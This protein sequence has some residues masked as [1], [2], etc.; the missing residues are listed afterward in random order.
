M[1][2][3]PSETNMWQDH[4]QQIPVTEVGQPVAFWLAPPQ[5][6]PLVALSMLRRPKAC[7]WNNMWGVDF[8]ES[9]G[10]VGT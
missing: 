9:D 2:P 5:F 1:T 6:Q 4:A 3:V 8:E 10:M 7:V